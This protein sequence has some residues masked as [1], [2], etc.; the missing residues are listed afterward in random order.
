[1]EKN[2]VCLVCGS[3]AAGADKPVTCPVCGA[4][5]AARGRWNRRRRLRLHRRTRRARRGYGPVPSAAGSAKARTPRALPRLRRGQRGLHGRRAG[6]GRDP[7]GAGSGYK[8]GHV[9]R[10]KTL[11]L[12]HLQY[13]IRG[14]DPA[15]RARSAARARLRLWRRRTKRRRRARTLTK[16]L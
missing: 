2:W 8:D 11:A 13:G 15:D 7:G 14:G 9:G 3:T 5:A 6:R 1:M 10:K 4:G 12:H 16:R